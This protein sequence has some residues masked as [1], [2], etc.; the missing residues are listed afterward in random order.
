MHSL[1]YLEAKQR[2]TIDF[3]LDYH[4]VSNT[5]TRYEMP[6][7][8]HEETEILFVLSG[9]FSLFLDGERFELAAGDVAYIASGSLHAGAP[10]DC[11][12][13][14]IVFDLRMLLNIPGTCRELIGEVN[15]RKIR[16]QPLFR[17]NSTIAKETV[18]LLFQGF[19]QNRKG[20]ELIALG[21]LLAFFGAVYVQEK[22]V[23]EEV[24]RDEDK[25]MLQLKAVFDLIE[26][27]YCQKLT[28]DDL[29]SVVH[30]DR[31]Y[32][33]RFFKQA[34]HM[35]PM[36]YLQY[37]RV[38]QACCEMQTTDKNVTEISLD[39]GFPTPTHFTKIFKKYKEMTP[40]QYLARLHSLENK[41]TFLTEKLMGG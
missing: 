28:L 22:Y 13:E 25:K 32:F 4:F 23:L 27:Q 26:A 19:R 39:V 40:S 14:C 34:T 1:Q 30:L 11:V 35:T 3:P 12:Y 36:Q 6:Y 37:Y 21:Y 29:A 38:E 24:N 17:H 5:H 20:G 18:Q 7:H 31:K 33:C 8:W 16:I 10:Q 2:G 15:S 41:A 9:R